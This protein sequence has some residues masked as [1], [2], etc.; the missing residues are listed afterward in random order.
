MSDTNQSTNFISKILNDSRSVGI[1]LI[2]ATIISLI[3][4]NGAGGSDYIGFWNW[5]WEWPTWIGEKLPHSNLLMVNDVLMAFFFFMVGLEI[6]REM[7]IGELAS[8]KQASLPIFAAIGGV[9]VP[10][11]L[12]ILFNYSNP[13]TSHG[14]GIP[15]ATDIAFA[16]GVLALIGTRAPLGLKVLLAALAIIDDLMA[17]VVI[18]LFYTDHLSLIYLFLAFAI[19]GI[20]VVM[21]LKKVKII[22][23]YIILGVLLWYFVFNSGVHATLAAVVLAFTIPLDKIPPLEH[24]LHLPV[25]FIVLPIFALANTAIVFPSDFGAALNSN[26]SHGIMAGLMLGKPLGIFLLPFIMVKIGISSLPKGIA[27]KHVIGMGLLGGI[28]FT[29]S[30]FISELAFNDPQYKDIAKIAVLISS[31]LSAI[32]GVLYL[33]LFGKVKNK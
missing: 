22:P 6:K 11:L 28:G 12:Y 4:S 10:A 14:W 15:M 19:I 20:L 1:I 16:L 25:S 27:W 32:F 33:L 21:N 13:D 23:L 3:W 9:L 31:T 24:K 17:I 29:M 8:V 26:V 5:E 18:A 7:K 2:I 30:I